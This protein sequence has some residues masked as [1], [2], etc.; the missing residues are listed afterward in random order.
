MV[1]L[2]MLVSEPLLAPEL[3]GLG[4]GSLLTGE[5]EGL[6]VA[7]EISVGDAILRH[8][9]YLHRF[10]PLGLASSVEASRERLL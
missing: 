7:R 3:G 1:D 10:E 6:V 8:D 4:D 9:G 2:P 5:K